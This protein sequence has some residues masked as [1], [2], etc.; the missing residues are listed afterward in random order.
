MNNIFLIGY[1]CTGKTSAGK[2]L[3]AELGWTF[4]DADQVIA[5]QSGRSIAESI[6]AM[7]W[8][9][10]REKEC[11][12]IARLSE[13][14]RQVVATGGGAVIAPENVRRMR[15]G[16][17]VIWLQASPDTIRRR[18]QADAGTAANRP[19]LTGQGSLEEI[20]AVLAEREPLYAKAA[21]H[22]LATDDL[23]TDAV[24]E[25]I[26]AMVENDLETD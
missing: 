4:V 2:L 1:R 23:V 21:H 10:F 3:A 18:M 25:K 15:S 13:R 6:T 5:D 12:V 11:E 7:G 16:G 9:A 17:K 20:G 26:I 24:V 19:S 14:D 8:A 22:L